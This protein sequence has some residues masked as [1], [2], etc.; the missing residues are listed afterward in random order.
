MANLEKRI[1]KISDTILEDYGKGRTI[2][3]SAGFSGPDLSLIHI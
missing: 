2:D 3:K 1:K